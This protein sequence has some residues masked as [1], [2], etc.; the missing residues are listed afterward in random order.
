M[1]FCCSEALPSNCHPL[2][3]SFDTTTR[4]PANQHIH[5]QKTR[6]LCL[7]TE[8]SALRTKYIP[9]IFTAPA[10]SA[11]CSTAE[12]THIPPLH[13]FPPSLTMESEAGGDFLGVVA[14]PIVA[15]LLTHCI[16]LPHLY[17]LPHTL[18][19][20][21]A[22]LLLPLLINY[23]GFCQDTCMRAH[24]DPH[25]R[26]YSAVYTH[27]RRQREVLMQRVVL[28]EHEQPSPVVG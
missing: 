17:T 10:V 28:L 6:L 16:P 14:K 9:S 26:T 20:P 21:A 23:S 8:K 1:L 7:H 4:T 13:L 3:G 25:I 22:L 24:T 19:R 2:C 12:E 5:A 15:R 11:S 18:S 27:T